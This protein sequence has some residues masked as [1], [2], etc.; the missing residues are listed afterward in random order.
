MVT[1]FGS[2]FFI[3]GIQSRQSAD[4]TFDDEKTTLAQR[5]L[6]EK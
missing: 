3:G 2:F 4:D 5:H 1:F 6:P